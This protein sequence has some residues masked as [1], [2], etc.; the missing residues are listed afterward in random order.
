MER[1]LYRPVHVSMALIRNEDAEVERWPRL[2]GPMQEGFSHQSVLLD[3]AVQYLAVRRGGVYIDGTVGEG[4]HASAILQGASPE[5]R[6]LGIDLDLQAL[7]RA[8]SRLERWEGSFSLTKGSYHNMA[9][10]A[11]HFGYTG[12][13]GILLDLGLS[14]LQLQDS[15]RG[16]SFLRDEPLDMRY[17]PESPLTA[18][19]VVNGYP[20]KEL[21]NI[22]FEY[23]EE[24]RAR[25]IARSIVERR[26]LRTSLELANLVTK[27]YGGRKGRTHPATRTF[28]ALR[29]AV[30]SELDN[31]RAGLQQAISLLKPGGMLV[32]ISYHSL[33]DRI[34]K[35]TL[36][37]ESK[38]CICPTS[39]P[40]CICDHTPSVRIVTRKVIT[41]TPQEIRQNPRSRSSRLRAAQRL[42]ET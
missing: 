12:P 27:V 28:Q 33:E 26:P 42:F 11:H 25:S 22:L 17:D 18:A 29:I 5:G 8:Q 35:Q 10:L 16:F 39:V 30:N 14:S 9:E 38:G 13:D 19:Q 20:V 24:P 6:L 15:G 41:P 23:G 21:A 1:V 31:L 32:T 7:E 3:E 37:R 36:T 40:V 4:G 34:V 2:E